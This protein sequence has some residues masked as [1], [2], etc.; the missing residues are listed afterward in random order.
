MDS[1]ILCG[2]L[3]S[4]LTDITKNEV[5]K[6][7]V[8]IQRLS[9]LEWEIAWLRKYGIK[10]VILAV[11]HKAKI[12]QDFL[13]SSLDTDYGSVDLSYS[14]EPKKL[15]SGGAIR[16]AKDFLSTKD[17]LILNGD[18]LTNFPLN[19]L[20][21]FHHSRSTLGTL[22]LTLLP[23]PYGIVDFSSDDHLI[24]S[25]REKPLLPH[26]LHAGVDI[27]STSIID[28]FPVE[29]QMEETIF[30]SLAANSQLSAFQI[31]ESFYWRSIDT[32][33]DFKEAEKGWVGL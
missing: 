10:H 25:F 30:V 20:L 4:R 22:A 31:A 1:I 16:F 33:K 8:K 24:S 19:D 2:G 7:L 18:I 15:G 26:W 9:I 28:D 27:F 3:G 13:G 23:S 5:P 17:F 6:P 11:G 32:A 29:G 21:S 12:V 14:I